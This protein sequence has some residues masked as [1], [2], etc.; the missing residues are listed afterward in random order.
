MLN[1]LEDSIIEFRYRRVYRLTVLSPTDR[2][3]H[4]PYSGNFAE[5]R[6]RCQQTPYHKERTC[7]LFND[8]VGLN[9][10]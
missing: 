2:P 5:F 3:F 10:H 9:N 4:V 1:Q 8:R 6:L 7:A